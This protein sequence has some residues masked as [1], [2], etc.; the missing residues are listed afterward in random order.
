MKGGV[1]C[2][3]CSIASGDIP[4]SLVHEDAEWVVFMS[5]DP[6]ARGHVL[7]I[8]RKHTQYFYELPEPEFLPLMAFTQKVAQAVKQAYDRPVRFYTYGIHVPH[9]HIHV[10]PLPQGSKPRVTKDDLAAD[11]ARIASI[12]RA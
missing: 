7:I 4:A 6:D 12:L 8:P 1:D 2:I 3:F 11:A 5:T 9:V 10:T